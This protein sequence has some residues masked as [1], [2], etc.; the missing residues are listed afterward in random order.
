VTTDR[1]RDT[2]M[3]TTPDQILA[4]VEQYIEALDAEDIRRQSAYIQTGI[5][6]YMERGISHAEATKRMYSYCSGRSYLYSTEVGKRF[7]RIVQTDA[8]QPFSD[9]R[10]ARPT[11]HAFVEIET[12]L[13]YKSA[14]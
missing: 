13:V 14:T 12:G 10:T 11:V 3:T 9:L 2:D 1:K 7:I 6:N 5:E 8:P 4:Y